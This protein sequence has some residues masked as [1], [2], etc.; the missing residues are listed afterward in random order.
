MGDT[1]G[2]APV[3]PHS[4]AL[5][6]RF[7]PLPPPSGRSCVHAPHGYAF[8]L[9]PLSPPIPASSASGGSDQLIIIREARRR[10][11]VMAILRGHRGNVLSVA[12]APDGSKLVSGAQV[13]CSKPLPYRFLCKGHFPRL[14]RGFSSVPTS[15]SSLL[16]SF[17]PPAVLGAQDQTVRLWG[18]TEDLLNEKAGADDKAGGGGKRKVRRFPS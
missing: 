15:T 7:R 8:S 3:Q 12:F 1:I 13:T 2:A 18:L 17:P 10:G 6:S 4:R 9:S 14:R 16:P 11:A 5:F